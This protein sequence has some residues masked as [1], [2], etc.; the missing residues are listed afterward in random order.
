MNE[1]VIRHSVATGDDEEDDDFDVSPYPTKRGQSVRRSKRRHSLMRSATIKS[2]PVDVENAPFSSAHQSRGVQVSF[3]EVAPGRFVLPSERL[4]HDEEGVER[5]EALS[6]SVA[7]VLRKEYGK[8]STEKVERLRIERMR[9]SPFATTGTSL[10]N[11][12][13]D[14][15][16]NSCWCWVFVT[17]C[18]LCFCFVMCVC[19]CVCV[20]AVCIV[21]VGRSRT[22]T[23]GNADNWAKCRAGEPTARADGE[24]GGN[25]TYGLL[26]QT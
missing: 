10:K 7:K 13:R 1:Q 5:V 16:G 14:K 3:N 19:L 17:H 15:V 8:K 22:R 9:A 18:F 24:G 21:I 11:L 20:C 6:G 25:A 4:Y 26:G 2:L 23:F 12:M